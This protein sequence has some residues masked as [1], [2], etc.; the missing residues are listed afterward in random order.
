VS[1]ALFAGQTLANEG[2]EEGCHR[3]A[4]LLIAG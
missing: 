1:T 2:V 3:T 4:R